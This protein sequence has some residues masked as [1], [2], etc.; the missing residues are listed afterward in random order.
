MSPMQITDK[1]LRQVSLSGLIN[2]IEETHHVYVRSELPRLHELVEKVSAVHCLN[3]PELVEVRE[4]FRNVVEE[5]D[6]HMQKEEQVLFPIIKEIEYAKPGSTMPSF[7]CGSVQNPMRVMEVEHDSAQQAF[8]RIRYLLKDYEI[9][10]D[11][12]ASY[13]EMLNGLADFEADLLQHIHK[14]NDILF[15]QVLEKEGKLIQK[16]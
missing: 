8:E 5:L 13:T 11:T 1:D 12:C 6:A 2:H 3:H 7:H 16:C 14:E 4:I 10:Q 15:P 9:P